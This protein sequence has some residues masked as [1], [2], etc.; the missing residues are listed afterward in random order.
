MHLCCLLNNA[1]SEGQLSYNDPKQSLPGCSVLGG[2]GKATYLLTHR[3]TATAS[4]QK[5][6]SHDSTFPSHLDVPAAVCLL[7]W[8]PVG[9]QEIIRVIFLYFRVLFMYRHI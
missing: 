9:G 4:L 1:C 5:S 2:S 8:P 3:Q 6:L 7:L